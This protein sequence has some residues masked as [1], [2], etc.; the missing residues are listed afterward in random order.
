MEIINLDLHAKKSRL[1]MRLMIVRKRV[2]V[3]AKFF[4]MVWI[5]LN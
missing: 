3:Q 5:K 2:R 1:Q 4:S